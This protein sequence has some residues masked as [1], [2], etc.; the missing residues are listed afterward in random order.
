M[1]EETS[2]IIPVYNEREG[3]L[4]VIESLQSLKKRYGNR[5][6]IIM[7]DDGSTDGTSEIIRNTQDI[8]LIR[9]PFNRGY[10]A[11]IKTGIRHA[12]YSTFIISDADGTYPVQDIPKLLAQLS[13]SEMVVGAR[14]NNDSNIPLARRPAKWVL[15]K[16]ANYLTG[17]KIPDLNSGFRAMKKDVVMKFI[18]LLPDGFSFT[19][20]I[21]LAMLTNDYAVEFIPIEYKIRS[22]R[23]KIRPIR[24][25]LNFLQ[26]I[27]RT[28]L[29]FDPLK[30]FLPMSAIF[31]ISSIAVL[32]LSYLFTPKIMDITTVILFIS[33]VQILAIG[34]I[35]DLIDKRSQP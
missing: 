21:T 22:G 32:V 28:V 15:N 20:T 3:I 11:A 27:I 26:L 17:T 2:I 5:W 23:S 9:H 24:D 33:G 30:I 29:Y 14:G 19:T 25:T 12:K 4:Q 6:E 13:K 1:I 18:H 8:I 34:M 7:V 31:F 16:L 10:G 35:A